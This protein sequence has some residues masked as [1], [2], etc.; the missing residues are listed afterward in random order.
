[1]SLNTLI[2]FYVEKFNTAGIINALKE[3]RFIIQETAGIT[4]ENQ[5]I[6][7]N[8]IINKNKEKII[9]N[10][11]NRRLKENQPIEY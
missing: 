1:M 4:L 8:L 3:I 6:N 9:K 2:N 11:L 7:Q 5:I 10:S